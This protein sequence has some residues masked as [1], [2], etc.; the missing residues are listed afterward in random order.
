MRMQ[1]NYGA[2]HN[3]A[4]HPHVARAW[5]RRQ[6][7]S[8]LRLRLYKP[9]ASLVWH[10]VALFFY[11]CPRMDGGDISR[12]FIV[13]SVFLLFVYYLYFYYL[14]HYLLT[15]STWPWSKVKYCFLE[16]LPLKTNMFIFYVLSDLFLS[17]WQCKR[18]WQNVI[19]WLEPLSKSRSLWRLM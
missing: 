4:Y 9:H 8:G 17:Y 12:F 6:T 10:T 5:S 2:L 3:S 14:M 15:P 11:T 18:E 16:I 1:Y 19:H 7:C 13:C